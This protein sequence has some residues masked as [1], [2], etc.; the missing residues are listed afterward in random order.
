M[1]PV[2]KR[3]DE[4][5]TVLAFVP[6][7]DNRLAMALVADLRAR[8]LAFLSDGR[9]DESIET[10]PAFAAQ[11]GDVDLPAPV[12]AR[13][14]VKVGGKGRASV[15]SVHR[16]SWRD[17]RRL[18]GMDLT[19][20]A[21]PSGW[22]SIR[23]IYSRLGINSNPGIDAMVRA[24]AR[25]HLAC[26][27]LVG[28]DVPVQVG[29]GFVRVRRGVDRVVFHPDDVPIL[30]GAAG[31]RPRRTKGWADKDGLMGH[32]ECDV[33]ADPVFLAFWAEVVEAH[34]TG[35]RLVLA[36]KRIQVS[37]TAETPTP[38]VAERDIPWISKSLE[39]VDRRRNPEWL[40]RRKVAKAVGVD[41]SDVAFADAWKA[42]VDATS[43]GLP[44]SLDGHGVGFEQR[45]ARSGAPWCL[46]ASCVWAFKATMANRP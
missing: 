37:S 8:H 24:V 32:L 2:P 38:S 29:G 16:S 27:H 1:P 7:G 31:H 14:R 5:R 9:G 25:R 46:R 4:W 15:L 39:M 44:P 13:L 28:A 43:A 6:Q 36:G 12:P 10:Y 23:D 30:L 11:D 21:I 19:S 26:R 20:D 45:L 41:P 22:L 33:D 42:L 17:M 34:A 40:D 3:V 35:A 18:T